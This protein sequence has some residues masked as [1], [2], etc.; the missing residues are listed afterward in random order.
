M[1]KYTVYRYTNSTTLKKTDIAGNNYDE[2]IKIA[3]D[4]FESIYE[5]EVFDN[6][7]LKIV[8]RW[9]E[10]PNNAPPIKMA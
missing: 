6:S 9:D 3:V 2:I 7:T 10:K 4:M 5:W 8:K 1:N